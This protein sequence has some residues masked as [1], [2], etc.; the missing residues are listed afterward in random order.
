ML[1]FLTL[2][3][4]DSFRMFLGTFSN[5]IGAVVLI[6]IILPWFLIAV[7]VVSVLYAMAA[8]FYRAS[9]RETKVRASRTLYTDVFTG[10]H[11]QRLEAILRSLLYSHFSES[12]SGLATIRAYKEEDRFLKENRG[13]VDAETRAYWMTVT[14]QVCR[15]P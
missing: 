7:A 12:L 3:I 8:A 11:S 13:R 9:A 6:S 1:S 15:F 4:A 5:I 10:R 2:I 14:N